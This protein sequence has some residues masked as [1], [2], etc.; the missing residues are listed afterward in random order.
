MADHIMGQ[1][2]M[3]GYFP[4]VVGRITEMHA[5][6]YHEH[7]GFDVSFETQVGTEFS[8]FIRGFRENRDFFRIA[9]LD[10]E[11]AGAIS[12][13]GHQGSGEGVRLRW[14][15]VDPRLQGRGIGSLLLREAIDFCK[16]VH[17]RRIILW[18]FRGLDTAR[19]LYE[20]AGFRLAVEHEVSQWGQTIKE[21]MFELSLKGD[22]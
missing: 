2:E 5:V 20:K 9:T 4:G 7:W 21:Q 16:R 14:F 8:E 22:R 1:V 12:I 10:G 3:K 19:S 17:Y 18:T 15:I 13:D 11:F 6:Y